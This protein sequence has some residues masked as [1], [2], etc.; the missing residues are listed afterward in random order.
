[1]ISL[2]VGLA[3]DDT[4][5]LFDFLASWRGLRRQSTN[6]IIM[7]DSSHIPIVVYLEG[8]EN[9]NFEDCEWIRDELKAFSFNTLFLC[10]T[11]IG[12]KG[13]SVHDFL[14]LVVNPA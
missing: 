7:E 13:L 14:V 3:W 5:R 10:A 8:N 2:I 4:R 12:F 9:R 11:A 6:C 1:M